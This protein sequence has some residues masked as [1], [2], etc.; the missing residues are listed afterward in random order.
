V[1]SH[2][3]WQDLYTSYPSLA[4]ESVNLNLA[5]AREVLGVVD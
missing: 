1:T 3:L 4:H 5:V 2:V